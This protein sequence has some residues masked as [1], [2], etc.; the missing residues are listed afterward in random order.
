VGTYNYVVPGLFSAW[1]LDLVAASD[2][3]SSVVKHMFA[4]GYFLRNS[5]HP[6]LSTAMKREFCTN[7]SVKFEFQQLY[8]VEILVTHL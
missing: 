6:D 3:E 8:A 2:L 5:Y 4:L 7:N 1:T